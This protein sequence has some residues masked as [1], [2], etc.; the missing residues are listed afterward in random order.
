MQEKKVTVVIPN[1]NGIKY[2]RDC[3]DS[4]RAQEGADFRV[5]IVD[6]ASKDGSLELLQ[7]EYKEA[8]LIALS[9][10]TG[11]CHAVN[12]GIKAAET[13]YVILL[14]NDTIVKPG[15][16]KALTE[17]IEREE[18]IFSVSSLMLSMQDESIVDDAESNHESSLKSEEEAGLP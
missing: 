5:L 10:N 6:N 16:V 4:L 7:E 18:K 9:E 11:F 1:Y 12:V 14:N 3:M 17:A 2:I 15:F 8:E 13:P